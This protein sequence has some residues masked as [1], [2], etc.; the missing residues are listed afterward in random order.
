MSPDNADQRINTR[1]CNAR[2]SAEEEDQ[3][4]GTYAGSVATLLARDPVA[5]FA[6]RMEARKVSSSGVRQGPRADVDPGGEYSTEVPQQVRMQRDADPRS[7]TVT[8]GY[9]RGW[10]C[11]LLF[12][13]RGQGFESP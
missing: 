7:G 2:Y 8:C 9:G 10:T 13:S 4:G 11:C 5:L 12:A 1:G 6:G 3:I